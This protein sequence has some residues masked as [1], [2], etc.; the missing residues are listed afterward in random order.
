MQIQVDADAQVVRYI[1]DNRSVAQAD[2]HDYQ[3]GTA[4]MGDDIHIGSTSVAIRLGRDND[5]WMV[6]AFRYQ[7]N[8][9]CSKHLMVQMR[10]GLDIRI[11]YLGV[12]VDREL[13]G[14]TFGREDDLYN[15]YG[16]RFS[17]FEFVFDPSAPRTGKHRNPNTPIHNGEFAKH[18]VVDG[19]CR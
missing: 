2:I 18:Y 11:D 8:N 17:D 7:G 12:N 14:F 6:S 5:M 1:V 13:Y 4:I 16:I 3:D 15:I 10:D 19:G 9:I